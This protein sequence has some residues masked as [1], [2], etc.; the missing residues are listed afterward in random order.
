MTVLV[1]QDGKTTDQS[2][3]IEEENQLLKNIIDNIHEAVYVVNKN[4]KI[5]LYNRESEKMENLDRKEV[6]GKTEKEAF[7][8]LIILLMK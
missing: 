6:L 1:N 2:K 8:N 7:S 4:G 5:I 3:M